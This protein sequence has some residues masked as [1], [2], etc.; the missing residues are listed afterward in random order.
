[1]EDFQKQLGSII[2]LLGSNPRGMSVSEISRSISLNRNSTAKYLGILLYTGRVEV[3]N[4]GRAKLYYISQR[5]PISALL[6]FS[7]DLILGLDGELRIIEANDNFLR[8]FKTKKDFLLERKIDEANLPI[9]NDPDHLDVLQKVVGGSDANLELSVSIG[10]EIHFFRSKLIPTIM[11]DG[12]KGVTMILENVDEQRVA[13]RMVK[14]SEEKFR[15]IYEA[16]RDAMIITDSEGVFECNE[17]TKEMFGCDD[18]SFMQRK[19]HF[20]SPPIQPN[21]DDSHVLLARHQKHALENG[22]SRFDWV[23]RRFD[24]TDFQTDTIITPLEIYGKE[25]V[26]M[27]IRDISERKDMEA[28]LRD[29]EEKYRTLFESSPDAIL[30]IE[31]GKIIQSNRSTLKVFG[32]DSMDQV[33]GA[34]PAD[35][36]PPFQPD[37]EVSRTMANKLLEDVLDKG[38]MKFEWEHLRRGEV[39]TAEVTLNS[40]RLNDRTIIQAKIRDITEIQKIQNDLRMNETKLRNILSSLHGAFIG[41]IDSDYKYTNFWSDPRLDDKYGMNSNAVIG[42]EAFEFAPEGKEIEFKGI[43]DRVFGTG[44]P[45]TIDVEGVL[46][47]GTF[48]QTMTLSPYRGG[49]GKIEGVVQY[50][51]DTSDKQ[52]MFK[53]LQETERL[54][55]LLDDHVDDVIWMTDAQLN[56]TYL[57]SSVKDLTGFDPEELVGEN[58]SSRVTLSSMEKLMMEIG[59]EFEDFL[60]GKPGEYPPRKIDLEL[61]RKD[62]STVWT[63]VN[64]NTLT[65]PDQE[66][67]GTVGITRDITKR[68]RDQKHLDTLLSAF[69]LT[70]DGI[71]VTDLEGKIQDVND[72]FLKIFKVDDRETV[73]GMNGFSLLKIDETERARSGIRTM[74]EKGSIQT[75]VYNVTDLT[76]KNMR[77]ETMAAILRDDRGEPRGFVVTA[78]DITR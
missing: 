50:S 4:L 61:S 55:K 46:P 33:I 65:G 71:I 1:M 26:L 18:V 17:A 16:A 66:P 42:R 52:R 36:S 29:N 75:A 15:A 35:L 43:I 41:V 58:I 11:T 73:L 70:S 39:F 25:A 3:R 30:L 38:E 28:A 19:F 32:F 14:D 40:T 68:R 5:F 53:K 57:S 48:T 74:L 9:F 49:E 6:D 10:D 60:E 21:G 7:S 51:S 2:N 64:V 44:E 20:F 59:K 63:E 27:V 72:S 22:L 67:I 34:H 47:S 62:G 23:H 12:R 78:K 45:V 8:F 24:G 54:Y 77:I 13:Q 37:G 56:Y 76:G 69:K 31:D